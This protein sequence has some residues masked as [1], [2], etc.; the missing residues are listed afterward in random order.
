MTE[1]RILKKGIYSIGAIDWDR[2]LFDALIPLPDGTSYNSYLIKGSSKN[3]LIDTVDAAMPEGLLKN[4]GDLKVEVL[5]Y[6]VANHA[7]QDHAGSLPQVLK[8]YPMAKVVTNE[9]CKGL[10][11]DEL[12]IKEERFLV[13]KDKEELSLGDKTIQ[14]FIAPWVHWPETMF[15][16]LKE[17]K[18]LFPCDYLGSHYAT[19]DLFVKDEKIIY[20]AAKRYY[21]EIMMPFRVNVRKHLELIKGLAIDLIAPSHGPIYDKPKFILDAYADWSSE[22]VKNEVVIPYVT[23]HGSTKVMVE[24][25]VNALT[26]KG[27]IVKQYELTSTDI[28]KLAM[29]LVDAAT[30]IVGTP[31]MLVGAHPQAA[32]A[33]F[34]VNALRPKVKN[35]GIIGSFGWGNK[36]VEQLA[37]MISSLKVDVLDPVMIKGYPKKDDLKKLDLL[38]DTVVEKHKV[39]G[40]M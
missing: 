4:L 14:F 37:G 25:L 36:V 38:A 26:G 34:L 18:I 1:Q 35:I 39:L 29:E 2:R 27:L 12:L 22:N 7:E 32:Y 16:Y 19:S 30:V 11:M 3:L 9:K 33:A 23:A 28:G 15:S 24:Y 10:L 6:V 31:A 40:L 21:A 20:E 8:K 13:I 5:D 17:D